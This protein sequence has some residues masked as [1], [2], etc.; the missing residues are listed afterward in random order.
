MELK[1]RVHH[2]KR[3]QQRKV[4]WKLIVALRNLVQMKTLKWNKNSRNQVFGQK[5]ECQSFFPRS[6]A[7]AA[8][9][10]FIN[11]SKKSSL[12]QQQQQ[13]QR[14]Q[15]HVTR[16]WRLLASA[17]R[18]AIGGSWSPEVVTWPPTPNPTQFFPKRVLSKTSGDCVRP[19][20]FDFKCLEML[21]RRKAEEN[22]MIRI[23]IETHQI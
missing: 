22:K 3:L 13:Q 23:K 8:V 6:S 10:T 7:A 5:K 15:Q 21:W 4:I 14:Q 2:G 1:D 18:G 16:R 17:P 20:R 19:A 12:E 11:L 9:E